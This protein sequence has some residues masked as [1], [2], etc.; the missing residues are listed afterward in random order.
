MVLELALIAPFVF[1]LLYVVTT[2]FDVVRD[3]ADRLA[4]ARARGGR[5]VAVP[6]VVVTD[7]LRRGRAVRDG[8]DVRVLGRGVS[9][10]LDRAELAASTVR[11]GQLDDNPVRWCELRG[12]VD[13]SGRTV[14]AGPPEVWEPAY[15]TLVE[16]PAGPAGRLEVLRAAVPRPAVVA[17]AV[18]L[19]AAGL[20]QVL[21]RTGQD[22][23]AT[24]TE[25]GASS[26]TLSAVAGAA[27]VG[28]LAAGVV[29]GVAR[30]R[31]P[32]TRLTAMRPDAPGVALGLAE[33][34]AMSL[35]DLVRHV[36]TLEGWA[37]EAHPAPSAPTGWQVAADGARSPVW[38]FVLPAIALAVLP[39]DMPGLLRVLILGVAAALA[40]RRVDLTLRVRRGWRE[41]ADEPVTSEWDYLAVRGPTNEW[42]VLLLLGEAVHWSVV[43]DEGRHPRVEGRCGVRGE[44]ADGKDVRLVIEGETWVPDGPAVREDAAS[45]REFRRDLVERLRAVTVAGER[46]ALRWPR[47]PAGSAL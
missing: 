27:A 16:G 26:A 28:L 25:V 22:Q 17:G 42:Y 47:G 30:A 45:R 32:R 20:L 40:V 8:E 46:S 36:G 23:L 13:T 14:F 9:V 18:A 41:A 5:R 38:W 19:A 33:L 44:L 39:D 34:R 11:R 43:L 3:R 7:T 21:W 37:D 15:E 6:V 35:R 2:C 24:V 31:A 12:F 4:R 1:V 10:V 29:V